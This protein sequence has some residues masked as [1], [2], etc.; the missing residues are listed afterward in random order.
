MKNLFTL[1]IAF[2]AFGAF[3]QVDIKET[4]VNIDGGKNGFEINIPYADKKACEKEMKDLFKSWKG[5]FSEKKGVMKA[6]DC[7]DKQMGENTFDVFG[8]VVE[9]GEEGS[10]AYIAIDLGG[11]YMSSGE[12]ASQFKVMEAELRNWAVKTATIFVSEMEKAEEKILEDKQKDLEDL[13]KDQKKK[14]EE[15]E[16]YKKKI[17]EN[18]KAVEQSKKDQDTKKEEIKTQEGIVQEVVKK[19]EGIK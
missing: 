2:L 19:K 15:I 9:N 3:G 8:T 4:N 16:D 13:E 17:E 10:S 7:K 14:E 11:A 18:E 5:S 12:H 6:N 1:A